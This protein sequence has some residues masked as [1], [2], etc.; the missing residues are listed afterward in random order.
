MARPNCGCR[1]ID[2]IMAKVIVQNQIKVEK[3]DKCDEYGTIRTQER[4]G[5][6]YFPFCDCEYGRWQKRTSGNT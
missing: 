4:P 3:C 5:T 1:G 6:M 2:E